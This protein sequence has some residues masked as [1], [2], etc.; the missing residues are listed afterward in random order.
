MYSDK[1]IHDIDNDWW[2]NNF[3]SCHYLKP[4]Y[5]IV[6][7]WCLRCLFSHTPVMGQREEEAPFRQRIVAIGSLDTDQQ[8]T[9]G[10]KK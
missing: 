8:R 9:Q 6:E 4:D 1:T 7:H 5:R 10:N 3:S 2:L